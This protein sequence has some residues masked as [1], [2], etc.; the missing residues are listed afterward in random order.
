MTVVAFVTVCP[1]V[2]VILTMTTDTTDSEGHFTVRR[3]FVAFRTAY[4]L[5]FTVQL[6]IGFVVV[7][8]P[9]FPITRVMAVTAVRSQ[10]TL[11]DVLF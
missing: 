4:I 7:E 9:V 8:I 1:I 3:R 6:E 11:V 2:L 5:V 10:R